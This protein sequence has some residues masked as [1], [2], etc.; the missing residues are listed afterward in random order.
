MNVGL[1]FVD[2]NQGDEITGIF[3]WVDY[4]DHEAWGRNVQYG[5]IVRLVFGIGWE[6]EQLE[7]P[8]VT[9]EVS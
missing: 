2:P 3:H 7:V 5:S 4:E 1:G 9:Y 6:D 8:K